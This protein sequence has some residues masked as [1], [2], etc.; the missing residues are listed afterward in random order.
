LAASSRCQYRTVP[1]VAN[2][3]ASTPAW[4]HAAEAAN[5]GPASRRQPRSSDLPL[6]HAQ[7]MPQQQ[8]LDLA[9]R[10]ERT[11][12]QQSPADA[13]ATKYTN[14]TTAPENDP[15]PALTLPHRDHHPGER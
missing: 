13:A 5:N 15:P 11:T 6:E 4:Q 1:G 9:L 10:S 7:L 2:S 14:D 12:A 3:T 8:D